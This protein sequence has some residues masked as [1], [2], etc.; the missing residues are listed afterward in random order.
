[1][2]FH[3]SFSSLELLQK[4]LRLEIQKLNFKQK[5][6]LNSY[7]DFLLSFE[8]LSMSFFLQIPKKTEKIIS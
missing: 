4:T 3:V 7:R 5:K 6:S 2:S 1:M 8:T